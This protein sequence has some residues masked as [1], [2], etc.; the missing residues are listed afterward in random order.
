MSKCF[1]MRKW[2]VVNG[3]RIIE[4]VNTTFLLTNNIKELCGAAQCPYSEYVTRHFFHF[5]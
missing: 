2:K 4:I 3:M 1:D 5:L